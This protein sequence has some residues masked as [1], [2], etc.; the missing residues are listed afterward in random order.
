MLADYHMHTHHSNDSSY[1]ME[2][3][4]VKAIQEGIDEICLTEHSDY[5]PMG[6]YVV[7]Y[8]NYYKEYL[9]LKE[10]YK[11]KIKIKFGCEFGMQEH[12]IQQ[13]QRDFNIYPFDFIILSNHQIGDKEF[14]TQEYQK[15]KSH[16]IS[17]AQQFMVSFVTFLCCTK[18]F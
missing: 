16:R 4:V 6:D 15:G 5:G 17:A 1:K 13:F 7:N 3:L 2:D 9:L 12:T 8:D 11:D 14:W 10:K 18:C